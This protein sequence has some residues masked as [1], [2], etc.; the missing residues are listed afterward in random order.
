MSS[1]RLSFF[2]SS[3]LFFSSSFSSVLVDL[4]LVEFELSIRLLFSFET[5]G[6]SSLFKSFFFVEEDEEVLLLLLL[7]L[8][9]LLCFKIL[10]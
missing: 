10:K 5:L 9:L 4:L 6:A 2:F 1:G 8:S 7:L 3:G